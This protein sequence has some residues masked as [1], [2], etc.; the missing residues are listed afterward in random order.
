MSVLF[1]TRLQKKTERDLKKLSSL[2]GVNQS[3][4][5][6]DV[7]E[8]GLQERKLQYA[9]ELYRHGKITLAR[10]AEIAGV[11]RWEMIEGYGETWQY[12]AEDLAED[13]QSL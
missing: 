2:L 7:L 8:K 13:M 4:L 3:N 1:T 12:T 10:A 6:R 9:K 11:S 5:A